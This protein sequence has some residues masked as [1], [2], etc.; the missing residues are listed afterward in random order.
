M[1]TKENLLI[2]FE[3]NR[4]AY[5]SGEE[6]AERLSVSRT[7]VWKAV[8]SLRKEGYEIDAVP[9]KGYCLSAA[10]DILS[11]QGIEKYLEPICSFIDLHVLHQVRST[12]DC[13]REKALKNL[14]QGYTVIAGS[15]TN[16][17]GRTG[18]SFYSPEDT[19][20]YMS[21]LLRP[22]NCSPGQAVKFTT[23]AAVAACQAIEK[24]SD[25]APRIKWVND[26]YIED[27][28]VS[29]ILTEGAVSLEKGS[30]EYVILGIG[31]NVYPPREGFP[32]ELARTAGTVFMDRKSDGK[33]RLAGEFLNCFMRFYIGKENTGY[34]RQY[35]KRSL[36][37]GKKIQVL[38]STGAREARALDIDEDCRLLVEYDNGT[39]EKLT[40]GE[41]SIRPEADI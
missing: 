10:T 14:P 32:E 24:V 17:K 31:M 18:R 22:E 27:K 5:F 19:G 23:M 36:V 29:G 2:I 35:R 11:V 21:I 1:G 25:R 20:I 33:N 13:L 16:G 34:A 8:N 28:K 40:A 12:N 6:L 3:E 15:Q 41:I 39:R 30:L 38:T 9:N 4:G 7:A 37:L 26:I